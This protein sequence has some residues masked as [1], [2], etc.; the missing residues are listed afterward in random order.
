MT[1]VIKF[2]DA[3]ETEA[4][5]AIDWYEER[6]SGLGTAFRQSLEAVISSIQNNPLAYPI[7]RG[8]KVRRALVERY[9]SSVIYSIELIERILII[10]I[11]HS[12]RNP[13]VWRGRI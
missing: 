2:L 10:S 13:I 7:V 3:A 1:R 12:S 11:F 4:A 6:E 5:E 9:P 8:S